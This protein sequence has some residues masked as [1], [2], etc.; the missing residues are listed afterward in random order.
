MAPPSQGQE[1]GVP[2]GHL[3]H[4]LARDQ[5]ELV[6]RALAATSP[7]GRFAEEAAALDGRSPGSV[8]AYGKHLHHR[9]DAGLGLHVHLG[10]QGKWLRLPGPP[11]ARPQVRLRLA[12]PAVAW[13]L[14]APSTCALIDDGGWKELVARLGP[15]P[16]RPD[17][18]PDRAYRALRSFPGRVGAA[19]LDQSVIA[20]IGNVLRAEGLFLAGI[21]PSRPA[22][23]VD[24]E[25]FARLWDVLVDLMR[26]SVDDGR[27]VTAPVPEAERRTV[28]EADARMV[29]KQD[30]C[31]RCG[32]P[33]EVLSVGGRT[34]YA[35]NACQPA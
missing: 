10:M 26:R 34:A 25:T 11:P 23:A 21:H 22:A 33:V 7:Q 16:L 19:L 35:C 6:G 31:R 13:D 1:L 28:A 5:Q 9:Y 14:I 15:D 8:E 3:L 4:R 2:E 20:G 27:I 32:S 12:A 24:P 29:Y 30:A 18:E 17:A